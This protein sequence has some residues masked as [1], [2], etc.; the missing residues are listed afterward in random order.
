VPLFVCPLNR[1]SPTS[2][3]HNLFILSIR[4]HLLFRLLFIGTQAGSISCYSSAAPFK[5]MW[6]R[7]VR[8]PVFQSNYANLAF[9]RS[10]IGSIICNPSPQRP[11]HRGSIRHRLCV[12][13]R[14]IRKAGLYQNLILLLLGILLTAPLTSC[15]NHRRPVAQFSRL[16]ASSLAR[17]T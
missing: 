13:L 8:R 2:A 10:G 11:R 1:S 17:E 9:P 14:R 3:T 5:L 15:G 7:K 16:L 4:T 6:K 12:L